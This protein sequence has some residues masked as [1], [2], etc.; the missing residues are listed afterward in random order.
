M[1][2]FEFVP[3]PSPGYDDLTS[4]YS[5]LGFEKC[6]T[7]DETKVDGVPYSILAKCPGVAGYA[8][9]L[10]EVDSR[11]T[12]N[13]VFPDGEKHELKFLKVVSPAFSNVGAKAEWRVAKDSGRANLLR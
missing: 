4:I 11:Q 12:I 8:L 1:K 2:G 7:I 6:E 3:D 5:D 13:V 9:E 10:L